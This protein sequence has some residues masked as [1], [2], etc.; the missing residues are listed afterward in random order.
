MFSSCN[1]RQ[2]TD[3]P[4]GGYRPNVGRQTVQN[5]CCDGVLQ[6][7][8]QKSRVLWWAYLFVYVPARV[9]CL[10]LCEHISR[11]TRPDLYQTLMHVAC[12]CGWGCGL[13]LFWRRCNALCTSGFVDDV[14]FFTIGPLGHVNI[15]AA[16]PL[17]H[18]AQA[19]ETI[20][21]YRAR[22]ARGEACNASLPCLFVCVFVCLSDCLSV[23]ER[24]SGTTCSIYSKFLYLLSVAWSFSC[25]VAIRYV[26]P[27]L[28][29]TSFLH[30]I[31]WNRRRKKSVYLKWFNRGQHVST[32]LTARRMLQ[33]G[34]LWAGGG[35]WCRRLPCCGCSHSSETWSRLV[36]SYS[37]TDLRP[38][39]CSEKASTC[40][41][42]VTA[43]STSS[44]TGARC[45]DY[46]DCAIGTE[47]VPKII[48]NDRIIFF[49]KLQ[50][51]F[52]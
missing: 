16:T 37:S 43:F 42:R 9:S 19:P 33:Q 2:Q 8:V 52:C 27:V 40:R 26:L 25:G 15:V 22:V 51:A 28:W 44:I 32:D 17:Q 45:V 46:S 12:S 13:L 7:L 49:L 3:T 29:M 11:T 23:R 50:S 4:E 36:P 34:H 47:S 18:H 20:R 21:V 1:I 6:S 30:I 14:V 31:A 48:I 38:P 5:S 24:I 39:V 35:V 10:S 41:P